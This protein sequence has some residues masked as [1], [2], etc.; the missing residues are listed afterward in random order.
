MRPSYSLSWSFASAMS[1][2]PSARIIVPPAKK[3]TAT[4]TRKNGM[5]KLRGVHKPNA[6]VDARES[7][8]I[9]LVG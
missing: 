8:I 1:A 6:R 7:L 3:T 9:R 5:M 2:R 4:L